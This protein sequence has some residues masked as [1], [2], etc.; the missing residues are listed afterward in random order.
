MARPFFLLLCAKLNY[1]YDAFL[2]GLE[3][4]ASYVKAG[5]VDVSSL[6][7]YIGYW[8]DDISSST[9]NADDAAWCA[10]LL[11]Y[12][13]FYGFENVLWLFDAFGSNIRPSSATYKSFLT[14]MPD[15]ELARQLAE[16]VNCKYP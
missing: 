16:S 15:Q 5:L 8:V 2:D 6:R 10:A 9:E 12:V 11:T 13:S 3:R 7:P 1:C 4:F 14:L